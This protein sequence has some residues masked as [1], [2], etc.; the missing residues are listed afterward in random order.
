[1]NLI[2][3]SLTR[4]VFAWILMSALIVFGAISFNRLGVSQMP[5]VD[6][7]MISISLSYEGASP[8]IVE[9]ELIDPLEE[10]LLSIEGVKEMRS[11]ARQSSG[12]IRLEFGIDRDIDVALQEVQT[13]LAQ[14]R[15]PTDVDPPI[16]RKQNP[17]D[18]PIMFIGVF[19][20]RSIQ[21]KVRWVEGYLLDQL[22]FLEGAGEVSIA[23]FS[24]RNLR[25]W[26]NLEKLKQADLSVLDIV[27]ALQSQHLESAAGRFTEADRELRVRWLGEAQSPDEV[28]QIRILRRGGSIIQDAVYRIQDV[29]E[30]ED[31]LSD[32]RRLA[33]ID[34]KEAIAISVRKQ[35]GSNEVALS[36]ALHERIKELQSTLPADLGLQVNIDFTR[37][38]EA[39]VS[40]TYEKLLIASLVTILI[41]F[42]FLGSWQAAL[43]ILFSI[44]T[45]V[46]GTF[47]IL[48]FSGFTLNLFTLLALTLS[49]SIVV[50]DAI[51]LLENIYRH[52]RM[53]KPAFQ[54]AYDGAIEIL[55]AATAATLAVVAIFIPVLVMEGVI[56]KF[57]FQ[58]GVTMSA[59]VLL[60]LLEAVTITPMRAAAFLRGNPQ[61][62]RL[63]VLLDRISHV[64]GRA[65]TRSLRLCLRF[66]IMIVS[67]SLILFLASMMLWSKLRQEFVPP[68][69]Q[70]L[71]ILT[72]QTPSGS[73]LELTDR[74]AQQIEEILKT[75]P[76]VESYFLSVG[77]GGG[78]Q[79]GS[80]VN[81]IFMPIYLTPREFR[82]QTHLQIME[83][84]RGAFR[85][86]E[87][88]RVQLRDNSI[89]NLTAG[90]QSPVAF[91]LT[92]PDL[93]VLRRK[94]EEMAQKL[95]ELRLAVDTDVDFKAGIPEL[96]LQPN[97]EKMA[98]FGVS[99]ESVARTLGATV[100]GQRQNR[101]TFDGKRYD[102]R[103]KLRDANLG[104][105][106]DIE[107][108]R[109]RNQFGNLVSLS[110]LVDISERRSFQS[111][112]RVNRQ[113]AVSVS[114]NLA[115]GSS[116][117]LT[118]EKAREWSK[119]ILPEG[120]GF[121]LEGAAAGLK[122][123]FQSLGLALILG[124]LV[125][126]MILAIQFN[127]FVHPITI[128]I[129]LPFSLS[130]SLMTLWLF[131][132]SLNLFSYIGIIVLMGIAKKNSIL[133][134]EFTNQ[135][136]ERGVREVKQALIEACPTRLRPILMTS[137][138]T[139][140]AALP[141]VLGDSVGQETRT[142][143][144]AVILGG[145][146]VSTLFTLFVVPSLYWVL[147]FLERSKAPEPSVS[148]F[149]SAG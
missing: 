14:V 106:S 145:T 8:E 65:Y 148:S 112:T 123:G 86:L 10:S 143:L 144:G 135:L 136:R 34:G 116:Q 35:R 16:I 57:F 80:D 51:M 132:L 59:A 60:S 69:D 44:P 126:Y 40:T 66:P 70:D 1:M 114:G 55:P 49:I 75:K 13:A 109:V 89:R 141:L 134:V 23:G 77:A 91:N 4:S 122:E 24:Q 11:T 84:L 137:A 38:T 62:T 21:E 79:G 5:D 110:Q 58:F 107:K 61:A 31:G 67:G 39:V 125:A 83:E 76:F 88:V 30:V 121:Q 56:G 15:L 74:A 117:A 133:L 99:I 37:S 131:D 72:A 48:Y 92:G 63:E 104:R 111:V 43:N 78:P 103:I 138:A 140:A 42:L 130:G 108:I 127:S 146:V 71:L 9:S 6:F 12:S 53:G 101:F 45:S 22:R 26:P 50:D 2:R 81:N 33:R 29:A 3:L 7:P 128:L 64:L 46:L 27:D 41:C 36:K 95:E 87:G 142:P 102:I 47:I 149:R 100:A 124:I 93:E 129:A 119:Q 90:R 54:A 73:S 18:S 98:A 147:S 25:I 85:S 19:G 120:Y 17:E 20:D 115:P 97:R 52:F 96:V 94:A 113:R 32:V 118:L 139:I 68:Q 28:G 105:V 82:E